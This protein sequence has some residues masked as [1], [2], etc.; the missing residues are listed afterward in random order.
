MC[1]CLLL[2]LAPAAMTAAIDAPIVLP[3]VGRHIFK[4]EWYSLLTAIEAA[5]RVHFDR[6]SSTRK[7]LQ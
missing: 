4:T 3:I 5:S 2:V 7:E 6:N 1:R